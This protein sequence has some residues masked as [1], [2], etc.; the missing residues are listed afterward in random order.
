MFELGYVREDFKE[1]VQELID[2]IGDDGT[3]E[4]QMSIL[5]LENEKDELQKTND[6]LTH[7]LQAEENKNADLREQLRQ[8]THSIT[9]LHDR[10]KEL[11]DKRIAMRNY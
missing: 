7:D 11:V 10:S 6:L 1:I 4:H 9:T 5:D 8:L 3:S 2:F